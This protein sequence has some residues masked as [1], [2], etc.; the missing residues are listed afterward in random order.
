[1]G[2][3]AGLSKEQS[4]VLVT[5]EVRWFVDGPLPPDLIAWFTATEHVV[6]EELRTDYYDARS[7]ESGVGLKYRNGSTFD[8]K[9]L[10]DD[11]VERHFGDRIVG[12]VGDWVKV[13]RPVSDPGALGAPLL[14]IEKRLRTRVYTM[15][16]TPSVGCEV[17][18]AE[19]TT[20]HGVS[21]S[22]CFETFGETEDRDEALMAGITRFFADSP[23][24]GD[25]HLEPQRSC[26][27][28]AWIAGDCAAA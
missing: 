10:L 24:P 23:L 7:A 3:T 20:E 2:Y 11:E 27:Y 5:R 12:L 9:Y 17:E 4:D 28:P 19:I 26:G 22:L 8:A 6:H 21:W 15:D 1:M 25:V 16:E 14:A 13:S 18:L